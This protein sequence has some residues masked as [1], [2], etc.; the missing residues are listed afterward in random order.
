MPFDSTTAAFP[1]PAAV[2][3]RIAWI[4]PEFPPDRGGVSDHSST[5]VSEL[6]AVGHQVLVCSRPH[7]RGF[8]HL[9]AELTAYAPDLVIL[10]YTPLGYAPNT[11]GIA[12]ALVIW[13]M[14]LRKRLACQAILLAHET[15]LA[16]GY[17]WQNRQF[18]LAALGMTQ[19]AQFALLAASFDSVVFSNVGAQRAWSRL[20]PRLS[21][22]FHAIR[23]CS[24]IPYRPSANPRADLEALGY[25]VPGP[26]VLFFGTGHEAV[27]FDYLEHAFR[28]L[29]EVEPDTRLVIV[30]MNSE[31]LRQ[32]RPTLAGL[33]SR[34]QALG[35]VAAPHVSLWLQVA[36]LVL[37]PLI[38]GVSARK[39][40]V[41]AALQHGQAVVTTR[42]TNTLDDI[43]WG[44][45][46]LLAPS[47][48]EAFTATAVEAFRD[49]KLCS[50]IG[51]SALAEYATHA[52]AA[53]TALHLLAHTT[54]WP[55]EGPPPPS[56]P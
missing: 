56:T 6:R 33:G 11:A 52:S 28:A 2:L 47:D 22:R 43:A 37:A 24:N 17:L 25:E 35:Y 49:P 30:G 7:E 46:C 42:G 21:K 55:S 45:I 10:A 34:V 14:R 31:K 54:A 48:R 20:A 26:T 9:D 16:A 19:I 50:A 32:V 5:I 39:G 44:E 51:R 1:P 29:L 53:V 12:P 27:R 3:R 4:T 40:T 23:I 15:S 18:K 36:R 8:A 13:A 38:E 41:M